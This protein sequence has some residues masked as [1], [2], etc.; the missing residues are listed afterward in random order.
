MTVSDDDDDDKYRSVIGKVSSA[1]KFAKK[2]AT[3]GI[4]AAEETNFCH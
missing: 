4:F 3:A 2:T 1:I